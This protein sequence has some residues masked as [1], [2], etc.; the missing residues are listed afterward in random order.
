MARLEWL[1]R[2][3]ERERLKYNEKKK[4][5]CG[6]IIKKEKVQWMEKIMD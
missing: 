1:K 6:K 2:K 3:Q 5:K 4:K